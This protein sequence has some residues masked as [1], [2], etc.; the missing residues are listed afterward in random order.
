MS[1]CDDNCGGII[2]N[3]E[4]ERDY[5]RS[6]ALRTIFVERETNVTMDT[7]SVLRII[8]N[9]RFAVRSLQG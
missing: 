2:G 5:V 1:T 3:S 9:I 7:V 4:R 8:V 6:A